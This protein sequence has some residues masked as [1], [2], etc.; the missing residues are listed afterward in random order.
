MIKLS[1]EK[2]SEYD[3][4]NPATQIR[5]F[6]WEAFASNYLEMVKNRAYNERG[7][8][9]E[10]EKNAALFTL[11]HVLYESL[12]LLAPVIPFVTYSIYSEMAKGDVHAEAFPKPQKKFDAAP[13]FTTQE[14]IELNSTVWKAKKDAGQS[15]KAEV[16][17][18]VLPEK[19]KA[20]ERDLVEMHGVKK[21]VR[22]REIKVVL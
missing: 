12:K 19:F 3:F 10:K 21:V 11:R 1:S 18:L 4:H 8:Y 20:V 14:I 13:E 16:K 9:T 6:I 15:L 2:F 5:N 17:E 7:K 22:G